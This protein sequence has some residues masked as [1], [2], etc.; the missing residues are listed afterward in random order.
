MESLALLQ[1][2]VADRF[3][4]E[5]VDFAVDGLDGFDRA[6]ALGADFHAENAGMVERRTDTSTD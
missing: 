6:L 3:L 5:T 4:C 2:V 1:F